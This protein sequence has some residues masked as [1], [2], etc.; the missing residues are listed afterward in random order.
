MP[1]LPAEAGAYARAQL[2]ELA[3]RPNTVV[4]EASHDV[5]AEPWSAERAKA[6]MESVVKRVLA[7]D[8][9]VSD[10]CVRKTCLDDPE[11]LAFQR[12]HPKLYWLLT[13]RALMRQDKYR[14]ALTALL[15]VRGRVEAGSVSTEEADAVATR[16]VLGALGDAP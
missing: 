12:R 6:V 14:S 9:A 3:A 5:V 2:E 13:D 1:P 4:Y 10:F 7:F 8:Y 11:A 15:A 16:T